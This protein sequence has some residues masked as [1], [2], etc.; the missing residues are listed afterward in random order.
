MSQA[1]AGDRSAEQRRI[2]RL[3]VSGVLVR[4]RSV[5]FVLSAVLAPAPVASA[6][7]ADAGAFCT[8]EHPPH[9]ARGSTGEVD[10]IVRDHLTESL[11]GI[12]ARLRSAE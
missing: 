2:Q 10:R 6:A 4:F 11:G 7:G 3:V 12:A 5:V 9:A 1:V 8:G